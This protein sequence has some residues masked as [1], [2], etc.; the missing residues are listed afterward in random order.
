[1]HQQHLSNQSQERGWRLQSSPTR[2]GIC[3]TPSTERA[4]GPSAQLAQEGQGRH[5]VGHRSRARPGRGQEVNHTHTRCQTET[6][7]TVPPK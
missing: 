4:G 3:A 2:K 7:R 6:Q 5:E 1:M